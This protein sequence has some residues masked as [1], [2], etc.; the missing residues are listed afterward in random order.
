MLLPLFTP[1][2][3]VRHLAQESRPVLAGLLGTGAENKGQR[4]VLERV[5]GF[6]Q[7]FSVCLLDSEF[8]SDFFRTY[9]IAGTPSYLLFIRGKEKT[10]FLGY[11]DVM[12][13]MSILLADANSGL[14][15]PDSMEDAPAEMVHPVPD[16]SGQLRFWK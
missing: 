6:A 1:T 10:R 7:Q 11:A 2:E 3:F 16:R 13:L 15:M 4:D 14:V 8:S 5:A 9:A 12:N